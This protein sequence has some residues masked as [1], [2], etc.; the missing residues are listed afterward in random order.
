MSDPNELTLFEKQIRVRPFDHGDLT[1]LIKA[2]AADNHE[3]VRPTHVVEKNGEMVGYLSL[4]GLPT[5]LV[6]MDTKKT[7]VKDSLNLLN[8]FENVVSAL[9]HQSFILPCSETSPYR[10]LI[11]KAGY[12]NAGSFT[13]FVKKP[14]T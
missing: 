8:C 3:I 9:G 10:P 5:C 4:G 12:A 1:N 14:R 13:L 7:N 2:A 11:E 6:W